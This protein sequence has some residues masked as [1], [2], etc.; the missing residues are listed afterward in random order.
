MFP[1][2]EGLGRKVRR[3]LHISQWTPSGTRKAGGLLLSLILSHVRG[4]ASSVCTQLLTSA[5][6]V[7]HLRNCSVLGQPQR[8]VT[9]VPLAEF[10]GHVCVPGFPPRPLPLALSKLALSSLSLC[11]SVCVSLCLSC[12][13]VIPLSSCSSSAGSMSVSH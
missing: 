8:V 12:S 10:L 3:H 2:A 7:P 9:L 5:L 1:R 13:V 4:P 11:H 6:A